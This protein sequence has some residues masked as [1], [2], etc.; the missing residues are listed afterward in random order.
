MISFQEIESN[1]KFQSLS[2]EQQETVR[3]RYESE[4]IPKVKW[5]ELVQSP[6]YTE[7]SE[8][9]RR[10]L[11]ERFDER[12]KTT[13]ASDF[14]TVGDARAIGDRGVMGDIASH[15][16]RGLAKTVEM[17]G[18]G[19]QMWDAEYEDKPGIL[20]TAGKKLQQWGEDAPK[21]GEIYR[22]DIGEIEGRDGY[23]YGKVMEGVESLGPS[24]APFAAGIVGTAAGG[25]LVGLAAGTATLITTF[26]QGTYQ[27]YRQRLDKEKPNLPEDI[28]HA[29]ALKVAATEAGFEY[30]SDIAMLYI[31]KFIPGAKTTFKEFA[32]E[33]IRK[34]MSTNPKQ[35]AGQLGGMYSAELATETTQGYI[36]SG[37][38]ES[39]GLGDQ[40][41][42]FESAAEVAIP[43][44]VVSMTI[45]LGVIGANSLQRKATLANLNSEDKGKRV[46]AAAQIHDRLKGEDQ[47]IA[48][49]WRQYSSRAIVS[50][51]KIDI[52]ESLVSM[53]P[54]AEKPAVKPVQLND[55]IMQAQT[56]EEAIAKF[57]DT[58][59]QPDP[60][61]SMDLPGMLDAISEADPEMLEEM[62]AGIGEVAAIDATAADQLFQAI[63]ARKSA[64]TPSQAPTLPPQSEEAG[65]GAVHLRE[66]P[67]DVNFPDESGIMPQADAPLQPVKITVKRQGPD[68]PVA[69]EVDADTELKAVDDEMDLYRKILDCVKNS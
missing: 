49:V 64:L 18:R 36:Q 53:A 61:A 8:P 29:A 14:M 44:A 47:Q 23:V 7:L 56:A 5:Q 11:A 15:G 3:Q 58:V 48:E 25:P 13:I 27:E 30:V 63:T 22:P 31:G 28:K 26:G 60:A 68:G 2:P 35:V 12:F 32:K 40:M 1:P 17:A 33:G 43:T 37:V 21:R 46:R 42:F 62:A 9:D 20:N 6:R 24:L 57:K 59:E 39:V 66:T 50:G 65:V 69:L 45:G 34:L 4:Y 52:D 10:T 55:E 16:A 67:Q 38:D 19:I 51:E 54:L 41:T